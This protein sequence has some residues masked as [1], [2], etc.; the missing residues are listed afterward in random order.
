MPR[1][2]RAAAITAGRSVGRPET[3]STIP[4][5]ERCIARWR[6]QSS[7]SSGSARASSSPSPRIRSAAASAWCTAAAAPKRTSRWPRSPSQAD[8][9]AV[10]LERQRRERGRR[11]GQ[12]QR[13][14]GGGD[15][16]R[17]GPGQRVQA[18]GHGRDQ[19][20]RPVGAREQLR[21]VVPRDVLD[22][23]AARLGD[24]AVA[25]D[26]GHADHEVAYAAVAVAQRAGVGRGDHAADGR[27]VGRAERRVER[28]H[29]ALG[30]EQRL[31]VGQPHARA[32]HR[33]EVADVVLEDLV[34][35]AR[36]QIDRAGGIGA[37]P[38]KLRAAADR[39]HG[40]P[41]RPVLADPLGERVQVHRA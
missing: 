40:L 1:W 31:R 8:V 21:D 2:A 37:A 19:P 34:E 30:G 11:L 14:A 24:G 27:A 35:R 20:E 3:L 15:G 12:P 5:S 36:L 28:E 16:R 32:E 41:G 23:L 26:H 29:L 6:F 33:G 9:E 13:V 25:E 22:H 18:H 39:P 10:G 38:G 4:S 7:T 17:V